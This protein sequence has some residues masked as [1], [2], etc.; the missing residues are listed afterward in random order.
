MLIL[1]YSH[2]IMFHRLKAKLRR[3]IE[4]NPDGTARTK[5]HLASVLA[6]NA[7]IVPNVPILL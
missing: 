1:F 2:Q 6:R 4:K 7:N 5:L 3:G